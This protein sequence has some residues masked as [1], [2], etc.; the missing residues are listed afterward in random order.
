MR[1]TLPLVL[2]FFAGVLLIVRHFVS[3]AALTTVGA[4]IISWRTVVAAFALGLGS[5]NL[6]Q[7]HTKNVITRA[8]NWD[9]SVIL[10][11]SFVGF[12][13][14]G[15][16]FG[17]SSPIY[18]WGFEYLYQPVYSSIAALLAFM[19][20]SASYRSFRIKDWQSTVLMVSCLVVMLGQVGVGS[21]LFRNLPEWS[22]WLM[23]VPNTAGMRGI[24]IGGSLGA[25]A[26]SVRVL[27]GMERG[28]I[29]GGQ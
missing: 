21:V 10:I 3:N 11:V 29:G 6:M 20:T 15:L 13:V 24:T 17:T 27:L 23:D 18:T 9:A 4:E 26:L 7:F 22:Q 2:G 14:V 5:V 8:K 28:Y 19:I 25:I 1:K 12:T 16:A